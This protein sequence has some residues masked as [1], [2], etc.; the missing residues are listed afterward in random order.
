[1]HITH[2]HD[3]SKTF[4]DLT[5]FFRPGNN[6]LQI[7]RLFQVFHDR[8][9]PESE[10]ERHTA[11]FFHLSMARRAPMTDVMPPGQTSTICTLPRHGCAIVTVT[12]AC[13]SVSMPDCLRSSAETGG[14]EEEEEEQLSVCTREHLTRRWNPYKCKHSRVSVTQSRRIIQQSSRGKC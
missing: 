3:F 12:A 11:S 10:S 6:H 8:T 4:G 2:F 9:N 1:M 5:Y 13:S 14:G 7:P